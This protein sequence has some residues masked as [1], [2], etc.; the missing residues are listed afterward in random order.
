[1]K[2]INIELHDFVEYLKEQSID[3]QE[4]WADWVPESFIN[5]E[6]DKYTTVIDFLEEYI[7]RVEKRDKL[8]NPI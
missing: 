6:Q 7:K 2:D 5:E 8:N 4:L 1:M 3:I